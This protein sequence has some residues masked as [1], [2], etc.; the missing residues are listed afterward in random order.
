ML[1]YHP[2]SL[3]VLSKLILPLVGWLQSYGFISF[4]I[5]VALTVSLWSRVRFPM[6]S[7]EFFSDI[8]LPVALW[9]WGRLSLYQKWVPG[10][11]PGVIGSRCVRLTTLP[12]S[13]AVVMKYGNL[14]FMEPSGPVQVCNGTALPLPYCLIITLSLWICAL[15]LS[16]RRNTMFPIY[17]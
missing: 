2:L 6:L 3:L 11:F 17:A 12:P 5:D 13:C 9:P 4:Y 16:H 10:I 15:P 1:P 7:L 14:N 8:I